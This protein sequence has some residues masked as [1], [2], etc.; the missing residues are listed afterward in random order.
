MVQASS[1]RIMSPRSDMDHGNKDTSIKLRR[2]FAGVESFYSSAVSCADL[3]RVVPLE[4]WDMERAYAP[5]AKP[6]SMTIYTQCAAFCEGICDFDAS[7]F[8]LPSSEAMAT[9]PQQR[10]LLEETRVALDDAA[11]WL[12]SPVAPRTGKTSAPQASELT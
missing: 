4:R 9:D 11:T 1:I 10:V 2:F 3:Q 8:R 7:L 5:S 12:Q 6:G